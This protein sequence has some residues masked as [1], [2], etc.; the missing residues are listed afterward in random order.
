M[1]KNEMHPRDVLDYNDESYEKYKW[2]SFHAFM[3][4][5]GWAYIVM[6]IS[7]WSAADFSSYYEIGEQN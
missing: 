7:N 2:L 6:M 1:P 3:V 5:G 4:L